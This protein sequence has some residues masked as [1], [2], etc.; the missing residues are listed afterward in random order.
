MERIFRT[1][2]K[3]LGEGVSEKKADVPT[4]P[5]SGS[6]V[7]PLGRPSKDYE[8]LTAAAFAETFWSPGDL[9]ILGLETP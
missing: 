6:A 8:I 4:I 3:R 5:E 9:E 1:V 2:I 7:D